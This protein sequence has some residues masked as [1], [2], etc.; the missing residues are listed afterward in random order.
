MPED[1]AASGWRV[2][3]VDD[4]VE[5]ATLIGT[6]ID[7]DP[8]FTLVG[9]APDGEA[10]LE[11]AGRARPDAVVLDLMMPR[12]DGWTALP[13]LRRRLPHARIVAVSAFPDAVTLGELLSLGVDA[14]LDKGTLWL[15]L[16]PVLAG[17]CSATPHHGA[18]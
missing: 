14:Y 18:A 11:L 2:L 13:L 16:L 9:T 5:V 8:R 4:D 10:A 1:T 3:V 6:L 12:M 15:E 7:V 17:L